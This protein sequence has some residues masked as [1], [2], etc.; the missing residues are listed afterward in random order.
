[1]PMTFT[2]KQAR[3]YREKSM[4]DMAQLL[5]VHPQTYSKIEKNP[6]ILRIGQLKEISAYLRIPLDQFSFLPEK[7]S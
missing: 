7:S 6:E 1:M 5:D 2:L 3:E 4:E